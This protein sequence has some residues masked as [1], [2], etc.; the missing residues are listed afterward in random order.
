MV[1]IWTGRG[2][3][4]KAP[5]RH[6]G[7]LQVARPGVSVT[8]RAGPGLDLYRGDE[9]GGIRKRQSVT[10]QSDRFKLGWPGEIGLSGPGPLHLQSSSVRRRATV[11]QGHIRYDSSKGNGRY[12]VEKS[13]GDAVEAIFF[14]TAVLL[15]STIDLV[16]IVLVFGSA[17]PVVLS[18]KFDR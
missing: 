3:S 6:Q 17:L 16:M 13:R 11:M 9:P 8:S 7:T 2:P 12:F 1:F 10:R 14:V 4:R 15:R 5:G 18:K